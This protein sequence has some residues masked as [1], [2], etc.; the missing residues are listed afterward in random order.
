MRRLH[1]SATTLARAGSSDA[2]IS[3]WA[4]LRLLRYRDRTS[5]GPG[6]GCAARTITL[7]G[8]ASL[9]THELHAGPAGFYGDFADSRRELDYMWHSHYSRSRQLLQDRI[10]HAM[11]AAGASAPR[12]WLV[13]TA[14][15]MGSGKEGATTQ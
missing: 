5:H 4:P 7:V 11:L 3:P 2:P 14:G 8:D 6:G 1:R 9:P 10:V 15:A 13:F 12:P